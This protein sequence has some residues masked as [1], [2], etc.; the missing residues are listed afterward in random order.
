M[1]VRSLWPTIWIALTWHRAPTSSSIV[2]RTPNHHESAISCKQPVPTAPLRSPK[3]TTAT[4]RGRSLGQSSCDRESSPF[5]GL[6]R[7]KAGQATATFRRGWLAQECS[8]RSKRLDIPRRLMV[9]PSGLICL[10]SGVELAQDG[11][12]RA[13]IPLA[14]DLDPTTDQKG[15]TDPLTGLVMPHATEDRHR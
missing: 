1:G 15:S 9:I 4:C 3:T 14:Q 13:V 5:Q 7:R 10:V 11:V 2:T 8:L 12:E 6:S